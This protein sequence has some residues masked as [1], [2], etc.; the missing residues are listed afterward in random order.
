MSAKKV[1]Q[2]EV[3]LGT[4]KEQLKAEKRKV[5]DLKIEKDV[6]AENLQD[7]MEYTA[8]KVEQFEVK[9]GIIEEALKSEKKKVDE[10]KNRVAPEPD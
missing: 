9:I 4:L 3:N 8:K 5:A 2:F 6:L 1:E 10:M 7:N